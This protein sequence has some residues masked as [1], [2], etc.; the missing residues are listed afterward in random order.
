MA[1]TGELF[2]IRDCASK[3]AENTARIAALLHF[4]RGDE[5]DIT[6]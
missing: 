6:L 4:F 5:G 3:I 1:S 2:E